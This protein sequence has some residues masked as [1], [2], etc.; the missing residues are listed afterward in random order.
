MSLSKKT[1]IRL[2]VGACVIVCV[3][4]VV[5]W[6]RDEAFEHKYRPRMAEKFGGAEN[7]DFILKATRM[8]AFRIE[9]LT[10]DQLHGNPALGNY[11]MKGSPTPVPSEI[12]MRILQ[13]LLSPASYEW[14]PELSKACL[15]DPGLRLKLTAGSDTRDILFCFHCEDFAVFKDGIPVALNDFGRAQHQLAEIFKALYPQDVEIQK[16]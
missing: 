8:E 15:F 6:Q 11:T 4:L 7:L 10:E 3:L 16:L 5:K 12:Q 9:K 13:I 1:C 14:N 2:G